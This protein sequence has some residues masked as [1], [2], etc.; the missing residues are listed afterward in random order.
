MIKNTYGIERIN[1]VLNVKCFCPLGNDWYTGECLVD[2]HPNGYIPDYC[3]V[4][5]W[6]EENIDGS[7][8]I[9]E[10]VVDKIHKFL[11]DTYD[12][13]DCQVTCTV[14]DAKHSTVIIT[15]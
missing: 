4:D 2:F 8:L 14:R 6:K 5:K 12:P 7:E 9:A 3:A 15:K 11:V 1:I 10:E 13:Y